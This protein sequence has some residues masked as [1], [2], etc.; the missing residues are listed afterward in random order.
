MQFLFY[1]VIFCVSSLYYVTCFKFPT[2]NQSHLFSI[3]NHP[4]QCISSSQFI[5]NWPDCHVAFVLIPT[6]FSLCF[7][8]LLCTT[9]ILPMPTCKS[10]VFLTHVCFCLR[11]CLLHIC[12]SAPL[13]LFLQHM[14]IKSRRSSWHPPVSVQPAASAFALPV[15]LA[16]LWTSTSMPAARPALAHNT[17]DLP[18]LLLCCSARGEEAVAGQGA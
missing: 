3:S 17:P 5:P 7:L 10:A 6:F 14:H 4:T 2:S 18:S 15:R 16:T 9:L 11:F 13:P 12:N 8:T 1:F